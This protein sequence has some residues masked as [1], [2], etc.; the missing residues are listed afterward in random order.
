M[1]VEDRINEF[2]ADL[3]K[4]TT[5]FMVQKYITYGDCYALNQ[6]QYFELKSIIANEYHLHP[7]Q[8]LIVGSGKLGFSLVKRKRYHGF[9]SDSDIDVAIVSP[10]L[11]DRIWL[12]VFNYWKARY[13]W[14]EEEK[15][16]SY[17]FRGWI[18]PDKLPPSSIFEIS[19]NWWEFFR[20]LTNSQTFGPFSIKAGLYKAWHFLEC[21]QSTCIVE[22]RQEIEGKI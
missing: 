10:D 11:F 8:V 3:V 21:Y 18:R 9:N 1:G 17:L 13:F 14:P 15:F 6:S 2:K 16:R 19:H 12:E 4:N 20:E 5:S 7:S 22:C